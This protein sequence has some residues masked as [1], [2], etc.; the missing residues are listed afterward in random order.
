[1]PTRRRPGRSW[2][3]RRSGTWIPCAGIPGGGSQRIPMDIGKKKEGALLSAIVNVINFFLMTFTAPIFAACKRRIFL[4]K[5]VR[6]L[7]EGYSKRQNYL[8]FTI[9]VVKR[10]TPILLYFWL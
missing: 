5:I 10:F 4:A 1:M 2:A 7:P 9:E 6:I 8:S 3:G